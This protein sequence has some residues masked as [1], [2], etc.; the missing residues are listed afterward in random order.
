MK[1]PEEIILKNKFYPEGIKEKETFNYY[2][3][4][5][6]EIIKENNRRDIMILLFSK[7][8]QPI[9]KR[10]EKNKYLNLN[11]S[12]YDKIFN[13]RT[14]GIYSIMKNYEDFGIIDIDIDNNF[15]LAKSTTLDV[16]E[17]L[18]RQ[19]FD[20]IKDIE[21]RYTGKHSFHLIV[22][23]KQKQRIGDIKNIL[24][25]ILNNKY[26]MNKYHMVYKRTK[27]IPNLD[28]SPNKYNG[29]YISKYSLSLW[30]LKCEEIQKNDLM[31][32]RQE[33]FKI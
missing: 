31:K 33:D 22:K 12:N 16:Y 11:N 28:L 4:I 21:I 24:R 29:A 20:T 3:K 1:N 10:K 14:I 32:I 13:G 7:F 17:Y 23:F 30:G 8:N 26:L 5:R 15:E 18:I 19:N 6:R 9:F 25:N 27:G 2:Q